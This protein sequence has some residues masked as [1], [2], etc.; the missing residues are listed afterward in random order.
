MCGIIAI[1]GNN[2][3]SIA[4][5][6]LNKIKH[7][8]L[9]ASKLLLMPH[10]ITL[11][12]NRLAINDTSLKGMQPFEYQ[13]FVGIFNGEIYNADE[14][15]K[16][17][18]IAT[19]SNAD[20]EIILP[21]F[22][23]IGPSIIHHLDGF[24]S[25]IIVNKQT[26]QVFT[27]RDYIGKKPLFYGE[28]NDFEFLASELKAIE[29]INTFELI[30]KGVCEIQKRKIKCIEKHIFPFISKRNLKEIIIRAVKKRLPK[31]EKM[32]GVFLSGGLD[33]S[34]IASIV[35]QNTHNV[36]YYTLGNEHSDDVQF[37]KI[38]AKYFQ[39]EDKLKI[40]PL[41]D[42]H[43][44]PHL[45]KTIVYHTESY[46]PSIISNGLSTYLLSN[47]AHKDGIKV[48]LS[49]EG[50]DELFCGYR[51]SENAIETF[52]T[53]LEL[54]ENM[55]FTELRRLDLAAMANTIEIRCP[56]LDKQVYAA[57]N[58]CSIADLIHTKNNTLQGKKIVRTC[59]YDDLPN[60][61]LE[62][63]KVSFDVGSGIRQLV[64]EHLMQLNESEKEGLKKIWLAYFQANLADNKY[65][66]AYPTFDLA[67]S[68]RGIKHK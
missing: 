1:L 24:Y 52:D 14:L 23:K 53:R 27:I 25:G 35:A 19:I 36:I 40:I 66:H 57:S 48:V 5:T 34:I 18:N 31:T 15:R 20:T 62:R 10:N 22:E 29:Q 59:F 63:H 6:A 11:G 46:N 28:S 47:A 9:D 4:E 2:S 61:I 49:G 30:P 67:I 51:I 56:F 38:V 7:R 26:N 54:I 68:N 55:H 58:D 44:L 17:W 64:V 21:L 39:I 41:P 33:S 43:E 3:Y 8:G 65:C 45:I 32:F 12:F 50:A 16:K 60:V 37:V 13:H 42:T